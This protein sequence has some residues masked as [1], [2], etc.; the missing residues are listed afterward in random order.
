[1]KDIIITA[2]SI[3]RE[4]YFLL[5]SFIIACGMNVFAII[6]YSRPASEL[7]TMIGFVA[8]ATVLIYLVL[9]LVRLIVWI[10]LRL[11]KR[12]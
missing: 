4:L 8:F 12:H 5:A 11:F 3:R 7:I 10:V 2:K 6:K 1:M 9:A